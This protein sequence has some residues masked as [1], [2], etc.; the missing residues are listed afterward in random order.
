MLGAVLGSWACSDPVA[1]EPLLGENNQMVQ[2]ILDEQG[3]TGAVARAASVLKQFLT[4]VGGERCSD[5]WM[6]LSAEYRQQA[7]AVA[8]SEEQAVRETCGGRVV[9]G[10]VLVSRS[11]QEALMGRAPA[12]MTPSPEEIPLRMPSGR[13]LFFMVQQDGSYRAF[14]LVSESSGTKIEPF[15]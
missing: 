8:G 2:Q 14:V 1:V 10:G 13:E 15:F 12:Y 3:Q 5:A 6:L 9:Q 11:W 4:T 7:V